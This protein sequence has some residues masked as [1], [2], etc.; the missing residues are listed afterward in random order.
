LLPNRGGLTALEMEPLRVSAH[1]VQVAA[2]PADSPAT[3]TLPPA[4]E[5]AGGTEVTDPVGTVAP[6]PAPPATVTPATSEPQPTA[7]QQ[8]TATQ[9]EAATSAPR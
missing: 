2:V 9:R 7:S 3:A 4:T 8:P 5:A 1:E 6:V